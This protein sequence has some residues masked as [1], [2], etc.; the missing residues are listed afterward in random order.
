VLKAKEFWKSHLPPGSEVKFEPGAVGSVVV[1]QMIAGQEQIGYVG[2]MPGII[3]ASKPEVAD[4]RIVAVAGSSQQQCDIFVVRKD[5]PEFKT[6]DEAVKWFDGKIVATPQGS[7][8]D[9]FLR[10][11]FQKLGVKPAKYFNQAPDVIAENLKSGKVD[12]AV[13]WEPITAKYLAEGVA[14]RVASGVDF[15]EPDSGFL[16]MRQDLIA[17]R[18][19]VEK[20]WLEAEL[21]AQLYLADPKNANEVAAMA[22]KEAQGYDKKTMWTALYGEYPGS[23]DRLTL[24]FVFTPKLDKIVKDDTAFLFDLKRVPGGTLRDGAVSDQVAREVLEGRKLASPVGVVKAQP[25]ADY[26]D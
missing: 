12:A 6:P 2:D 24:D 15:N 16:V 1:G 18:P 8:A 4:I 13:M 25:A 11:V 26:K 22:Q 3:A 20:G 7:C 23:A 5:A 19:D 10:T 9:R 14:R 21:D 17:A